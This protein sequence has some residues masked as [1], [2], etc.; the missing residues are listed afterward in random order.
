LQGLKEKEVEQCC[1][2]M[3]DGG[4]GSG[5][6]GSRSSGASP[7]SSS[8]GGDA[9]GAGRERQVKPCWA[10]DTP[11]GEITEEE[12]RERLRVLKEAR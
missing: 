10:S 6:S 2:L 12:Y 1:W 3:L 7:C 8:G 11:W 4:P 9:G 5:C